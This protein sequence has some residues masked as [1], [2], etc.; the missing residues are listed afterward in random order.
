MA[1]HSWTNPVLPLLVTAVLLAVIGWAG[2][3][4]DAAWHYRAARNLTGAMVLT[5]GASQA[6]VDAA[7][8][9]VGKAMRWFPRHPDYLEL[10]GNLQELQA[11]L[12]GM[13]GKAHSETLDS[14][15]DYYR[16]ALAVRP[17]WPHG[18]ANLLAVKSKLVE[19]DDEFA[20]A[21]KRSVETGPWTPR[22][23]IQVADSGLRHWEQL[24]KPGREL[25]QVAIDHALVVQPRAIF[26]VIR[27]YGRPD[28]VCDKSGDFARIKR[29]CDEVLPRLSGFSPVRSAPGLPE[30]S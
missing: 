26:S 22:V 9:R 2:L 12:P 17:L 6:G 28:L 21:M 16:Q 25:V 3:R 15:A 19:V 14:A 27:S 1:R 8:T 23:Q 7:N 20:L 30:K 18:W 13:V 29:W 11:D 5:G 4:A 10:A 24:D